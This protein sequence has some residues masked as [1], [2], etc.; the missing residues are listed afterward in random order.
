MRVVID[1]QGA[2]S[3]SRFRGIGRYSLNFAKA[4]V[5]NRGKNE[6]ILALNGAFQ[7]SIDEIREAFA[8][9]LPRDCIRVWSSP[10]GVAANDPSSSNMRRIA[11]AL[12][13]QFLASLNP[14]ILHVTSLFEG[15][16]DD[17]VTDIAE[18]G[19]RVRV[20]CH[21][22]DLIPLMHSETFLD[23]SPA[24]NAFYR[25]KLT[26]LQQASGIFTISESSLEEINE[27][28]GDEQIDH[29]VHNVS[30]GVDS[31][32]TPI[33]SLDK[34]KH[35]IKDE[36]NNPASFLLYV[37][38]ADP[39]KNLHR[40]VRAYARLPTEYK[41]SHKLVL[42]GKMPAA[43]HDELRKLGKS[44]GL[45]NEQIV[46]LGH[47]NDDQLLQL[48]RSCRLFIF[49]SIH[50]GFGLPPLEAMACGT[51]VI[52]SNS[53]SMPEVVGNPD[54][55]FDP[56]DEDALTQKIVKCLSSEEFLAS[57]SEEGLKQAKRFSWDKVGLAAW[58]AWE[59]LFNTPSITPEK[60][61]HNQTDANFLESIASAIKN[62]SQ[63][64]SLIRA[65]AKHIAHNRMMGLK[66]QLLVDVSE[67]HQKDSGTGVQ[68]VVRGYLKNL[69]NDPPR[70]FVVN[71]VYASL[72]HGYRYASKFKD[73]FLADDQLSSGE[74]CELRWQ[75]GDIFLV[76]DCQHHVQLSQEAF[77]KELQAD[78]VIVKFVVYDLLPIQ[79]PT[80][81]YDRTLPTLHQRWL[82][83]AANGDGAIC[84]SKA[85]EEA[86]EGWIQS[87]GID[88]SPYFTTATNHIGSDLE[89][90]RPTVG[91]PSNADSIIN[92]IK[93][94]TSFLCVSTI[95]PRKQQQLILN[96]VELLWNENQDVNLV[97]VGRLGWQSEALAQTLQTHPE[98]NSR[99]FWL[100][101]ISDEFLA[102][103]YQ[104]CSC[105]VA[106]SLNEGFGLSLV[107]AAKYGVPIVANDIPV[108]RE[109][110]D[111]HAEFFEAGQPEQLA[112]MLGDWVHR[113]HEGRHI[114]SKGLKPLTWQ[115]STEYL[116]QRLLNNQ[117]PKH[118]LM[119][120]ISE[121]VQR[122]AATGIQ[123]VV[124]KLCDIWVSKP[125]AGYRVELVYASEAHG[126]RY[127]ASYRSKHFGMTHT[128]GKDHFIDYA[129]GDVFFAPDLAPHIQVANQGLLTR[130]RR[131]GVIVK[132]LV[133]DLLPINFP[134]FFP[135]GTLPAFSAWLSL[136]SEFD[137]VISH[138]ASTADDFTTWLS[139]NA[140]SRVG[141][142]RAGYAHLGWD[143]M[144]K[145]VPPPISE[146]REN[147]IAPTFI[148][149]G[150]IEPRKGHAEVL[151][152]FEVAWARDIDIELHIIG[153]RG[154]DCATLT[155]RL[156]QHPELGR[157]LIWL[158]AA[159]DQALESAYQ[160]ADCL[161]A[162]SLGE[163]F[164]L[165][166]VEAASRGLPIIARDIRVFR[167]IAG[168]N[169]FYFDSQKKEGLKTGLFD[170]L[171]LYR[172]AL[173]PRSSDIQLVTWAR[174]AENFLT[175]LIKQ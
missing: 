61:T 93:A 173:H 32:F 134:Q 74:D 125:P 71:P 27:L 83:L 26:S 4:V 122:D 48:Y 155:D 51:P 12:R 24:Y 123:R 161:I 112:D 10:I 118:Q 129:P 89:G 149:V 87:A 60:L 172:E 2:Q 3:E 77:F 139:S 45:T 73:T 124:K 140:P 78:G 104:I 137:G 165:P 19:P 158:D 34:T 43:T 100:E 130:M 17:A 33:D 110:A 37:G 120:D 49:P 114:A 59:D 153:K 128:T 144:D 143:F 156:D 167:E 115:R 86:L 35:L 69:L 138:S 98:L 116:K 119:I 106:A 39:T 166:I 142:C 90:S 107:E 133:H 30:A 91:R 64:D 99:L 46:L 14:D 67:L 157:R 126:Y 85:T 117:S 102:E 13:E 50:E 28:V 41:T 66:R 131:D 31:R 135:E 168:Q 7:E 9:L 20:T 79:F 148:M 38:G 23:Q 82:Q 81:F 36:L 65:V 80:L 111:G 170:W 72:D 21:C 6:V 70:D 175:H 56:L 162:A 164:G 44:F 147:S 29:R 63:D 171:E 68:R 47:V 113:F 5:R 101:G 52:A 62:T 76:L 159:D 88:T 174:S 169:A 18:T 75:R 105:V 132:F 151:D 40:L 95:E 154:W 141:K 16:L 42:A 53:S 57:L 146:E 94:R 163:G 103:I 84:I 1:M 55:L 127:A 25:K 160:N 109:I 8:N 145:T 136:V 108:F 152:A 96:A 54:A 121:L 58:S 15:F 150:T 97:L 22:Y 92:L 11:E